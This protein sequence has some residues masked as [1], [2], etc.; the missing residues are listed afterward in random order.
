[1]KREERRLLSAASALALLCALL[2]LFVAS[3]SSPRYATNFWTDTNLYFTIGRGMREGLMP[4]RDL[5]YHKGPLLFLIYGLAACISDTSFLGVYLLEVVSLFCMLL[6]AWRLISLFGEGELTLCAFPLTAMVTVA[7]TAFNQG[8][9]AEEF[10]LPALTIAVT[11][12]MGRFMRG[13]QCEGSALRLAAFGA[14][15]AWV[16]AIKY[17]D[18]GLFFGVGLFWLLEEWRVSGFGR[19]VVSGLWMLAG[20]AAVLL[21]VCAFLLANGIL[22]DCIEVYFVQ[23][24]FSYSGEPMTLAGHVL[25]ALAYLRTQSVINPAVALLAALGCAFAALWLLARREK[26]C[27]LAALAMPAGAGLLLLTCYWG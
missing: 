25:N 2:A 13:G 12:A 11:A 22:G 8:G 9:C 21:P 27:V 16:F 6:A 18:C 5:F 24:L 3:T 4:Y 14:A 15:M 17:T 19:A 7:C 20:F 1:M 10:C 26:G 23:N